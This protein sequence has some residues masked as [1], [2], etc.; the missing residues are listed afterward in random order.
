MRYEPTALEAIS[1]LPGQIPGVGKDS[2][3]NFLERG[4]KYAAEMKKP[5][6]EHKTVSVS[7]RSFLQSAAT[8]SLA[9][10]ASPAG[11][12]RKIPEDRIIR[13]G[14]IGRDGHY[15]ILLNSIPRLKNVQ[16][17]AYAKGEPGEDTAWIRKYKAWT[18]RTQVFENYHR[19]LD[20]DHL[21]VVGVC[22]PFY[23]NASAAVATCLQGIN[24]I[25]EK[26]AATTPE[27]LARL[28]D[29]VRAS[30]VLYSI[31]LDM[32]GMPIFQAARKAVRSGAIGEP[33]LVSGQKSY[34]WGTDR[35]LYYKQ[36][37]TY[38]GTIGWVGIHALDYMRWVSG[39]DYTRVAAW[40]GNKAHPQYPGCE[41]HAGLLFQLSNGGTAVCHLD[42]LRPENAPTHGDSRL[43]IAGSEGVLEAFEVGN[44][45]NLIS[46][47]GAVG[48][49]PLPPAVDLFSQFIGALRGK[50]EPLISAEESFSI[51]R[52]C[53]MAR[54]AADRRAW[55]AL[56][57]AV[58]GK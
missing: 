23:Q 7:R 1:C 37:K 14:L 4:L 16:L 8:A 6:T 41:D 13:V 18:E 48:D 39:Q 43:R 9:L 54:E 12:W 32:R 20:K 35:P 49:L 28:H 5:S 29:A 50:G 57:T 42:F 25:S 22:L 30:G 17:T 15:D 51:T 52:V 33:V 27:D 2:W 24:V 46:P 58:V 38:G 31:M 36:R 53:L 21:D 3:S 55:V 19:M 45:V 26:P 34:V 44:R 10:A 40:E 47:K 11:Q 56:Q